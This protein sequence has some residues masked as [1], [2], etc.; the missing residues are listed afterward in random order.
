VLTGDPEVL[1]RGVVAITRGLALLGSTGR[2]A[3]A[4]EPPEPGQGTAGRVPPRLSFVEGFWA[5]A[6]GPRWCGPS[7]RRLSSPASVGPPRAWASAARSWAGWRSAGAS[8]S[9]RG[10]GGHRL[11]PLAVVG[12]PGRPTR[13]EQCRR[14]QDHGRQRAEHHALQKRQRPEGRGGGEPAAVQV[15]PRHG[16]AH[17]A[18]GRQ[19][20]PAVLRHTSG[21]G[22]SGQVRADG[23]PRHPSSLM[24]TSTARS[25]PRGRRWPNRRRFR[26]EGEM[27]A[28]RPGDANTPGC[29]AG[30]RRGDRISATRIARRESGGNSVCPSYAHQSVMPPQIPPIQPTRRQRN[31]ARKAIG[32]TR[33]AA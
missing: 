14:Q 30:V 26:L 19:E 17:Q 16:R 29:H 4:A 9:C 3:A 7:A 25:S 23:E 15:W 18:G 22:D 31:S 2:I 13:R 21:H 11:R 5:W 12:R 33:S 27:K 6:P 24:S 8:R 28:P 1:T 32:A 10:G 20:P